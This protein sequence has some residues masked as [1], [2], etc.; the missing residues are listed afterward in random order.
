M[1]FMSTLE[2]N[3]HREH[4][5]LQDHFDFFK[6]KFEKIQKKIDKNA[7][8]SSDICDAGRDDCIDLR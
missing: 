3:T 5:G 7:V 8:E 6:N 1:V 4:R 2:N